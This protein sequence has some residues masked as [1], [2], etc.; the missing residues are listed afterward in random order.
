MATWDQADMLAKLK[1]ELKRPTNDASLGTDDQLYALLSEG[2]AYTQA[3]LSQHGLQQNA[4]WEQASTVDT[5]VYTIAY[6]PVGPFNCYDGQDS[7]IPLIVGP[8]DVAQTD[9]VWQGL[10]LLV[11][12]NQLRVFANGL[13]VFYTREAPAIT[14]SIAPAL[15]PTRA[16]KIAVLHAAREWLDRGGY[17][18]EVVNAYT[19]KMSRVLF[20]DPSIPGDV[21]IVTSRKRGLSSRGFRDGRWW[22]GNPNLTYPP[23]VP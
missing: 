13:W 5:K 20:G 4:T 23:S 12:R 17:R 11:P 8:E 15:M 10:T 1:L 19:V 6:E 9:L 16:R 18:E 22:I 2:L 7:T 14:A 3:L 21:G